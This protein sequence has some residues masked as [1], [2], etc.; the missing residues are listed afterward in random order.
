MVFANNAAYSQSSNSIR[1][2][3]GSTGVTVAGNVVVGAV[4]GIAGGYTVGTGLADFVNVA[5]NASSRNAKPSAGSALI[6]EGDPSHA[7]TLDITGEKRTNTLDAGAYNYTTK[8]VDNKKKSSGSSGCNASSNPN[9]L[10]L[11]C[12]SMIVLTFVIIKAK[13]KE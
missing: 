6:D 5:Y 3:S 13:V 10:F 1:F 12:I 4:V 8:P 11:I 9:I 2:P 7:V